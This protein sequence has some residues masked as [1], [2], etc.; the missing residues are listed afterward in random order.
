[1]SIALLSIM[2]FEIIL[3]VFAVYLLWSWITKTP[4]Y[5]SRI[6]KL[7][8]LFNNNELAIN[9]DTKF[10]D[11][12]SG[13]G[14]IITWAAKKG[15]SAEGVEYNPFLTLLSRVRFLLSGTGNKAKVYNRNF[16]NHAYYNYNLVYMYLY[17]SYMNPLA[18]KLLKELPQGS[19][20]ITN[21]FK[22]EHL[23][24]YKIVDGFYFYKTK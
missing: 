17:S 5:P 7:E 1:M 12:G 15:A 20:I 21:T 14:R 16:N 22:I 2:L 9:N 10:V 11:I 13:D 23:E 19:I 3:I 4:F 8:Q 24:P 18:E 6:K